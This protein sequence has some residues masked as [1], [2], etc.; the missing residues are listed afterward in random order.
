MSH[1]YKSRYESYK[2]KISYSM[3]WDHD[4]KDA[5]KVLDCKIY[6]LTLTEQGRLKDY[7]QENLEKGYI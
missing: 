1:R 3:S 4:I 6:P 7:V 2:K 5:P